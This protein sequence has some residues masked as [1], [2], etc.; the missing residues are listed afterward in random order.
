MVVCVKILTVL[1]DKW[2]I[3]GA[4]AC[5]RFLLCLSLFA[6]RG[7]QPEQFLLT[8]NLKTLP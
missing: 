1:S 7:L 8:P 2:E 6:H 3:G 5:L 4:I